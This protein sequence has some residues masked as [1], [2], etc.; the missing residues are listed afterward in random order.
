MGIVEV[1][2]LVGSSS[3]T[4]KGEHKERRQSLSCPLVEKSDAG[5]TVIV[6]YKE[7]K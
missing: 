1:G 3:S 7:S 5:M 6:Y 4:L 2:P